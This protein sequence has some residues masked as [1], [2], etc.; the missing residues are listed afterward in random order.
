MATKFGRRQILRSAVGAGLAL[1]LLN[2]VGGGRSE[3]AP[4]AFPKRLVLM[5]SP[6]GSIPNNW[7]PSGGETDF[8]LSR[9]LAPLEPHRSHL[10]VLDNVDVSSASSGPGDDHM[11]GMG[12]LW[13]GTELTSGG[14][15]AGGISVD[16]HIAKVVGANTKFA[17]LEFGVQVGGASIFDRMIYKAAAQSMPPENDPGKA[18]D[19]IFGMFSADDGA[20]V[21]LRAR[22]KSVLDGVSKDFARLSPK[23]AA[24]DRIKTTA[25]ADA[26]RDIEKRLETGGLLA[27][28]CAKPARPAA[29][30][31]N[32]NG[33]YPAV[34]KLQMDLLVMALACDLTRVASIQWSRSTGNRV[35]SWQGIR[36]SH[37]DLSHEGNSN[38]DAV[39]KLT[40]INTWY[41]EQVAY[42]CAAMKQIPEGSGTMLDNT[43]IVWGNELGMGNSHSHRDMKW[44]LAGSCGGYFKTGRYLNYPRGTARHNDLLVSLCHAMG[45]ADQKTFGNPNFSSGPLPRLV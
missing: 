45:L 23:L 37:H 17:S 25:Y 22:R 35:H 38:L 12:Q 26:L 40:K 16:Q 15:W 14:S 36:E 9:I 33:N 11:K 5:F 27:G 34:G 44:I 39:E 29:M 6:N 24:E 3:A 10:L 7:R 20:L 1:P 18:F 2:V 32:D 41:A 19:R 42:L 28:A 4:P 43:V 13:T 21:R 31:I 8:K 30:N